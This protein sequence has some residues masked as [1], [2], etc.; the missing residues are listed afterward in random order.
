[1][2]LLRLPG[3]NGR[4]ILVD[5]CRACGLVWFDSLEPSA[6]SK[7]GWTALLAE[8]ALGAGQDTMPPSTPTQHC[9]KC[10]AVLASRTQVS[11]FGRS[12]THACPN[13]HGHAQRDGAL[14]ASRGL[15]RPLMLDERVLLAGEHRRLHCLPC[16]GPLDG[17]AEHCGYCGSPV[18]VFDLPRLSQALG[19]AEL[20]VAGEAPLAPWPCR[21]CGAPVDVTLQSACPKCRRP[22]L[23]PA[24]T[25]L[26]RLLRA[27]EDR[28]RKLHH[29]PRPVRERPTPQ[30]VLER[31]AELIE[32]T[33]SEQGKERSAF[34]T[35][36]TGVMALA[37]V[38]AAL[39]WCTMPR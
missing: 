3:S 6:L 30:H 36:W 11:S 14:L 1:M 22:V 2:R 16:G 33:H 7:P 37:A 15:F 19:L 28:W 23:A 9:P 31:A 21:G 8:M 27:A 12:V 38:T 4:S 5:H 10:Q 35:Q 34:W 25:D 13:G 39:A 32:R 24:L 17:D 29:Q 18:T 26:G 20:A